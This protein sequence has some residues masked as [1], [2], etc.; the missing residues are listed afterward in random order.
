MTGDS[1]QFTYRSFYEQGYSFKQVYKY[2]IGT[3]AG[4]GVLTITIILILALV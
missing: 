2:L 4:A 1:C 3:A